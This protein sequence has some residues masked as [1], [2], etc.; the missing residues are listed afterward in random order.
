MNQEFKS[1]TLLPVTF[2]SESYRQQLNDDDDDD[3]DDD[4]T[5][6]ADLMAVAAK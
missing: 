3:D 2:V 4:A 1:M 6:W 5:Q